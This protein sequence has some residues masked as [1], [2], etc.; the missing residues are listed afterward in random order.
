MRR[1][2]T[3]RSLSRDPRSLAQRSLSFFGRNYRRIFLGVC[4]LFIFVFLISS[5]AIFAE[6]LNEGGYAQTVKRITPESGSVLPAPVV[7]ARSAI[8]VEYLSGKVLFGKNEHEK[9]PI[10]STTKILT[11][12]VARRHLRLDEKITVSTTAA[13]AGEQEIWL[14]PGEGISVKDLLYALLVHSANDA[15]CAIAEKISGS[16]QSFAQTMN[17]FSKGIGARESHFTNPHGLDEDGHYSTAYDMALIGR[18]LLEDPVLAK[19]VKTQRHDIPWVSRPSPRTCLNH[20][21]LLLKYEGATGIKTGYTS[22]A[23]R[24]LVGSATRGGVSLVAVVLN[25]PDRFGDTARLLDYGFSMTAVIPIM[26]KGQVLGK[27]RVS[28]FPKRFVNV[29]CEKDFNA[30][31][32]QGQ[33]ENILVKIM[34]KERSRKA[35]V[36]G[37]SLGR[38]ILYSNGQ[39]IETVK[40]VAQGSVRH[41]SVLGKLKYFLW[42]SL[43][44]TGKVFS[45]PFRIF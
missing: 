20:N 26:K 34:V 23:G 17:D 9:L 43:C 4:A 6:S 14:E 10:A 22:K 19:I 41:S 36:K 32:I 12:L 28:A 16:L 37:S 15:A 21:E 13:L 18:K 45:A 44:L 11:A 7:Q 39:E 38:A 1:V 33:K 42:Y 27:T 3:E 8:L 40:L 24:C 35:V 5:V 2:Y 25:S 31:H 29:G 30:V